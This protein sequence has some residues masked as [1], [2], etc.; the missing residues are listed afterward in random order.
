MEAPSS[1]HLLDVLRN[2]ASVSGSAPAF[3]DLRSGERT[4]YEQLYA[5]SLALAAHLQGRGIERNGSSQWSPTIRSSSAP[6][7]VQRARAQLAVIDAS[8]HPLEIVG[9][10]EHAEPK[11]VVTTRELAERLAGRTGP[12]PISGRWADPGRR[13]RSRGRSRG[14]GS[15]STSGSTGTAKGVVLSERALA[16]DARTV[17]DYGLSEK[18]RLLCVL[19]F[20]HMNALLMTGWAPIWAG[21]PSWS[22]RSSRRR[23]PDPTGPPPRSTGSRCAASR[24]RS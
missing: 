6:R 3:V 20:Y 16:A 8:L 1:T 4:S 21:R 13:R 17:V 10:L 23:R 14:G 19:P 9:L 24:R 22:R 18:D 2:R 7:G 12:S 11:L 5:R 15:S